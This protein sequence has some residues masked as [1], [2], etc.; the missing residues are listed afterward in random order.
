MKIQNLV[1]IILSVFVISGNITKKD[2]FKNN[3]NEAYLEYEIY[4][5][6]MNIGSIIIVKSNDS[7]SLYFETNQN[8]EYSLNF[9]TKNK[10]T[11]MKVK[12]Y[13]IL[14]DFDF[15]EEGVISIISTQ[16]KVT[17]TTFKCNELK[18]EA[19]KGQGLDNFPFHSKIKQ[20]QSDLINII[21]IVLALVIVEIIA[22]LIISKFKK[23]TPKS[24]TTEFI[25]MEYSVE[26]GQK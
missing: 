26:E 24:S 14:Y 1:F 15:N 13:L 17:Y 20:K 3:V 2:E 21:W 5:K 19:K 22:V 4:E 6:E 12:D 16:N 8:D 25:E 18:M 7:F 11:E 10:T 23:K 9:V